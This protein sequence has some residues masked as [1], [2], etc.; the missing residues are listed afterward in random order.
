[1]VN[2][3]GRSGG[4]D[5]NPASALEEI[6]LSVDA[7]LDVL[8]NA[9]RRYLLAFLRGQPGNT[10][11]FE[12]VATHIITEVGREQGVQPNHDEVQVDLYH[13]HLPKLADAG[14]VEYDVRSEA[15][16][17]HPNERLEALFGRVQMV[18]KE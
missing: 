15:I 7:M 18:Q 2:N 10:A 14:V 13:R 16:R 9:H 6:P 11:S 8:A 17:Y 1:M 3:E 12:A 4:A 5:Q